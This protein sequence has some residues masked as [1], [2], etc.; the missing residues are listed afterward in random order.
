MSV[1]KLL[2]FRDGFDCYCRRRE[3]IE[4]VVVVVVVLFV[5]GGLMW[6]TWAWSP[7]SLEAR[8]G[9][10]EQRVEALEAKEEGR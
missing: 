4:N 2:A 5:T 3:F 6:I 10:M 9:A 1:R 7:F 8:I